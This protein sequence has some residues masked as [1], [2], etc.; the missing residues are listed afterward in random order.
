M[1]LDVTLGQEKESCKVF[2]LLTRDLPGKLFNAEESASGSF[3]ASAW[4]YINP[5]E[6]Y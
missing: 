1:F 4:S 5:N 6:K 2:K 3:K